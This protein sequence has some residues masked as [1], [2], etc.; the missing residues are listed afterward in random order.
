MA[1]IQLKKGEGRLLRDGGC[2]VFDNEIDKVQ[3]SYENGD[4]VTVISHEEVFLGKGYINGHSKIR[5]RI[6]SRNEK[7][8]INEAFFERRLRSAW[9]YRKKIMDVSS[10]RIVFSDAD[11]LP[12]YIADKYEDVLVFQAETLGIDLRK[13]MITDLLIKILKED[14]I[15]LRGVYERSDAKVRVLEGLERVKGFYGKEFDPK[16]IITEN[17][18]KMEV[19]VAEGQKTGYFLDQKMNRRAIHPIVKN[20]RVLDC[21]THTGSFALNAAKAGAK[22]VIAVDASEL[23][24]AQ[25]RRNALL[26]GFEDTVTFRCAD[27][28]DLLPEFVEKGELFDV[29]ILDPPAFTKSKNSVKNALRGYREINR[30]G[31]KLVKPGGFLVTAS[32]SENLTPD[33]FR[34]VIDEAARSLHK[35]LREVEYKTQSPDHPIVWG[36]PNTHYLKF[37]ILQVQDRF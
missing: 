28:L 18:V 35:R 33:L 27:V 6:L 9:E 21:F 37:A 36:N 17:G 5:V 29:V 7:E 19:D 12:G 20:A 15:T 8:E 31:L 24:V 2:W 30:Q 34:K 13:T 3:G 4:I 26:N 16:V 25:G 32:C 23:A 11:Q 22:E 1:V 10:C 14:G